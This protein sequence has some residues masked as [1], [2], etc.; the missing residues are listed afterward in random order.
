MVSDRDAKV[1]ISTVELLCQLQDPSGLPV[2][3]N[4][5]EISR[6]FGD[7]V[8]RKRNG[9]SEIKSLRIFIPSPFAIVTVDTRGTIGTRAASS[10]WSAR[11]AIER[12][13][14]V[15]REVLPFSVIGPIRVKKILCVIRTGFEEEEGGETAGEE[16]SSLLASLRRADAAGMIELGIP[17]S[18][19]LGAQI[20][21]VPFWRGSEGVV[22]YADKKETFLS[23]RM[24]MRYEPPDCD[25][26]DLDFVF[27]QVRTQV[28]SM[29]LVLD[30]RGC[31]F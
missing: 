29:N 12:V 11:I 18:P 15:V 5:E 8:R 24:I 1:G 23:H 20:V 17:D 9:S 25:S 31:C 7:K 22:F 2:D 13:C 21:A 26:M 14:S 27:D 19:L 10:M 16:N 28:A 3:A 30:N 4:L 6:L